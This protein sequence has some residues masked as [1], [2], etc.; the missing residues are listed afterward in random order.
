MR[1]Y[2]RF[3]REEWRLLSYGISFTFLSS[4]GQTF[5]LSLFVPFFLVEFSLTEGQFGGLYSAA[6][7]GGA[8]LL[9][10]VGAWIDRMP[11]P[12]FTLGVVALMAL[13][14]GLASRAQ[15]LWVL[16]LALVGLRLSGQAL[17]GHAAATTM[18]RYFARARGKA[19]GISSVGFPLGEAVLPLLVTGSLAVVGWRTSWVLIALAVV[20]LF[21]PI[22]LST[23]RRS[24]VQLDPRQLRR[25]WDGT[26]PS[27]EAQREGGTPERLNVDGGAN[28]RAAE[29]DRQWRRREVL[30]DTRFWFILPAAFLPPFWT[31]GLFLYQTSIADWKGWSIAL[32]ASAFIP[33][34]A[35]RVFSALAV[36]PWVDRLSARRIF[37]FVVLPMGVGIVFLLVFQ[38][39]WAAYAYMAFMGVTNGLSANVK[40]A[41]W[42]ELYGVQHLGSI[43]SMMTA[44]MVVSTAASPVIVGF[45]LE[46]EPGLA[47]LL[48]AAVASVAGGTLLALR[49]LPGGAG[50]S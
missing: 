4:F 26:A 37:P 28:G 16:A 5:L 19:L 21:G 8:L 13:S 10:W 31:T 38:E 15:G 11:L 47:P 29:S 24:G 6:T 44:L 17:S 32:M 20:G 9:P 41:M 25:E 43:K 39:P 14:A 33:F 2:W 49:I 27:G 3:F 7:L 40:S 1:E 12:R 23:I 22:L 34:A 45:V 35:L 42:A 18:A 30:R 46:S 50:T 36:G 48:W